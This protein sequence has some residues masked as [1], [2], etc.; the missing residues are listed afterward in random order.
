MGFEAKLAVFAE[1]FLT[2]CTVK[3]QLG[4]PDLKALGLPQ[5]SPLSPVLFALYIA[6]LA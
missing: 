3:M 5:G 1:S 2:G 6:P 4:G